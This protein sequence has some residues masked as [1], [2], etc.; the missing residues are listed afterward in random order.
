MVED[1]S[2]KSVAIKVVVMGRADGETQRDYRHVDVGPSGFLL[3]V[4]LTLRVAHTAR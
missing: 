4:V 3:Y 1:R 2:I